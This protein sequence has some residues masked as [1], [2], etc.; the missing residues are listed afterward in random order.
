MELKTIKEFAHKN[1]LG[2]GLKFESD[3]FQV[4]LDNK[5]NPINTSLDQLNTKVTQINEQLGTVYKV[6]GSTTV[7]NINS[8]TVG[9]AMIGYVYNLLDSGVITN[10][11]E[12]KLDVIKGSNIV[13]TEKGWDEFA[14]SLDLNQCAGDNIFIQNNII[15]ALGY[16]YNPS[17]ESITIGNKHNIAT[18]Y[19]AFA[20]GDGTRVTGRKAHAE[21]G[22]TVASGEYTHAEGSNTIA[23]GEASHAEGEGN[24][25]R[26]KA[27]HAEGNRTTAFN[28]ASHSEGTDTVAY[29]ISAHA[30]GKGNITE[31]TGITWYSNSKILTNNTNTNVE[32]GNILCF[33]STTD[34]Y[35]KV[36]SKTD[37]EIILNDTLPFSS[38]DVW[39]IG[40][41]TGIAYG[42]Y[43]H[44]EGIN[45]NAYG[46]NS[47][48]EGEGTQTNNKS[49]H[50]QGM[51]NISNTG[52]GIDMRTTLCSIGIGDSID[53]KNAHEVMNNGDTFI[54]GI[55][56]YDGTNPYEAQTLQKV[57]NSKVEKEE[58]KYLSSNDYTNSDKE[59]VSLIEA[60]QTI[61]LELQEKVNS[62][63]YSIDFESDS[64]TA[65]EI[66]LMNSMSLKKLV[67]Y[68]ITGVN[69]QIGTGSAVNLVL[70]DSVWEGDP[71]VINQG[72]RIY[73]DIIKYDES[74]P[75]VLGIYETKIL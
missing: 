18:G 64:T 70:T 2:S 22:Q 36:V 27:A 14:A 47:H 74:A 51:Y 32:I 65:Q 48:T 44:S 75:A 21:G 68:N 24:E 52:L 53:R 25:T 35:R 16:K 67:G 13:Y 42:N 8:M 9:N 56:E 26:G 72:E 69:L 73:W 19:L 66:N 50:A 20:Q 58:G 63:E 49:E 1:N 38:D 28:Q 71:I 3:L 55:G 11:I 54:V 59:K 7:D 57:V 10:G 6:K 15:S 61:V 60:L 62:K 5:F 39:Y 34:E 45:T 12:G 40:V 31:L 37:T 41:V 30:E 46:F 17:S 33:K 23:S 4:D 43:S 29:G